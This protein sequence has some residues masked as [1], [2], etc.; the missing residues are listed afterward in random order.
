MRVG[1]L[2]VVALT[3]ATA[4]LSG[5]GTTT[6]ESHQII[7]KSDYTMKEVYDNKGQVSHEAIE[8]NKM[9]DSQVVQLQLR[10]MDSAQDQSI[11]ELNKVQSKSE[12]RKLPNPKLYLYFPAKISAVDGLVIPA[13]MTEFNM[14]DKDQ[15]ALPGE[16]YIGV[17]Q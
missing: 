6:Y 5:C 2:T 16:Q 15:Y 9:R 11:Y 1:V 3:V 13:W 17:R 7:P 8:S 4:F 14:Y 10:P 12:V